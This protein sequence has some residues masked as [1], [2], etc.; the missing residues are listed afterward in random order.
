MTD[1]TNQGNIDRSSNNGAP[2]TSGEVTGASHI[3]RQANIKRLA[4]F[5]GVI[6]MDG[7]WNPFE[8]LD[9]AFRVQ[10]AI[11]ESNLWGKYLDCLWVVTELYSTSLR[12]KNSNGWQIGE[13]AL[14]G[15]VNATAQMR[16]EAA[17]LVITG[18]V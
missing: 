6:V 12:T 18:K 13:Y 9:D 5:C 14:F 16:A 4:D 17:L 7:S 10:R 15:L 3:L 11:K 1:E 8:N 2:G